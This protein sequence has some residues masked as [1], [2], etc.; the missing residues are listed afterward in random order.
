MLN[1]ITDNNKPNPSKDNKSRN[2]ERN[3]GVFFIFRQTL[4]SSHD[5]KDGIIKVGY[6][7]MQE[8]GLKWQIRAETIKCPGFI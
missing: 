4:E 3:D 1:E 8:E 2:R 6:G 7:K 5:V